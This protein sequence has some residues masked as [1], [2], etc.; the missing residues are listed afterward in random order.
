M[1]RKSLIPNAAFVINTES[2][3]LPIVGLELAPDGRTLRISH[4]VS[5]SV[6]D[7]PTERVIASLTSPGRTGNSFVGPPVGQRTLIDLAWVIPSA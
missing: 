1:G 7:M 5:I 6:L 3:A 4:G 2:S